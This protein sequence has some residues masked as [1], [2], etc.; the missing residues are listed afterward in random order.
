MLNLKFKILNN[1]LFLLISS[2]FIQSFGFITIKFSTMQEGFPMIALLVLSFVFSGVRAMV[3]QTLL[4]TTELSKIYP[5]ASLVQVL[6]L[7]Y[8]VVLFNENVS[9]YNMIGLLIMLSGIY[10]MSNKDVS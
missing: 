7:V 6:I 9:V 5:Y 10:Y 3:W 4:K 8:S 1:T 2:I